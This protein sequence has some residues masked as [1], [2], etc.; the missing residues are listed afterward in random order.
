MASNPIQPGAPAAHEPIFAVGETLW[1]ADA[2]TSNPTVRE[3]T[4]IEAQLFSYRVS[5]FNGTET[6]R[7]QWVTESSL[8][9]NQWPAWSHLSW[10][11]RHKANALNRI[12]DAA[13][14]KA[15]E[16]KHANS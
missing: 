1:W 7:T 16:H 6:S 5:I 9:R 4:V 11:V 14:A 13:L 3:V 15:N 10:A 2:D 12:A 8:A